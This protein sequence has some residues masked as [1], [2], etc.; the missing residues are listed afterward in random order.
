M[1]VVFTV[2]VS[3]GGRQGN[4]EPV[5]VGLYY[6]SLSLLTPPSSPFCFLFCFAVPMRNE[7]CCKNDDGGQITNKR[8][9]YLIEESE[10]E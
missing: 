1:K 8:V 9:T 5:C 2:L 3:R 6:Y 4:N 7:L 10:R